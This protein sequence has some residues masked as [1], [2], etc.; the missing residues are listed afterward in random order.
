MCIYYYGLYPDDERIKEILLAN[1]LNVN[2][3][4]FKDQLNII[5][6][7]DFV[8]KH[9]I[10]PN[11]RLFYDK[12]IE[13]LNHSFQRDIHLIGFN[14][15]FNGEKQIP[16]N[17][18]VIHYAHCDTSIGLT[19]P[20]LMGHYYHYGRSFFLDQISSNNGILRVSNINDQIY[21]L[22]RNIQFNPDASQLLD[23]L[24]K[25][26]DTLNRNYHHYLNKKN[27]NHH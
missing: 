21:Y 2:S 7:Y 12:I 27:N 22:K 11:N 16:V 13:S 23:D 14:T 9:G 25:L 1:G 3:Q 20:E 19:T 24:C 5:Q 17:R 10:N 6:A 4:Q 26:K 15:E 18:S 8:G